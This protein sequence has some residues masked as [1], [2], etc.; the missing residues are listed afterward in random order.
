MKISLFVRIIGMVLIT[1]VLVGGV[2]YWTSFY[3]LSRAV[4]NYSQS[5]VKEMAG[6][7]R[8]YVDSLKDKAVTTTGLLAERQELVAALEK[9]NKEAVQNLANSYVKARQV[10]VLTVTDKDGNVVA[11]GH[12]DKAGDN[13]ST[14][15]AVKSTLAGQPFTGIEEGTIAKLSLRAGNPIKSGNV[16]IGSVTA[17][18]D[19]SSESFVDEVKKIYGVECTIFQGDTRAATTIM[20]DGKRAIGTR[21]DNPQVIETVLKKGEMFLNVNKI[22]GKNYDTAYWPLK[23]VEG[24]IVGMFFIGKDREL[25]EKA[26]YGTIIPAF[27]AALIIGLIM[28]AVNYYS[29][30]RIVGVLNH[31]ISGLTTSHEQVSA[32]SAHVA[33]ASQELAEGT[34][35]QAASL[36]ET[37][38]SLGEMSS[39]TIQNAD[40]AE[41]A[42]TMTEDAR[43]VVEKVSG[44]M[45]EMSSAIEEITKMSEDT[46]KIVKNIDEIAFQ[47]NLLALN[48]A[49]EAA[50]AGE[51]GAGFAVVA[52]EVRNLAMRAAEAAKTTSNLIENTIKAVGKGN[53][54][55]I[56]TQN[57][58]KE[59]AEIS[60]KI[61]QLVDEI[62]AS[63]K[64]QA[65]GIAQVSSAVSEMDKVT[66][67]AAANAE[68]SASS[69]EEMKTQAK[70][71]KVFVEDLVAIVLGSNDKQGRSSVERKGKEIP[72]LR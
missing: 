57:A 69:S 38:A 55:T 4:Y 52:D 15:V 39:M 46:S 44:H 30:Q 43:H 48:A 42:R 33:L 28:A 27:I 29:V 6:L 31:V 56:A 32:A 71:M 37:S 68:A 22:L 9:G 47:T 7:A 64:E 53:D 62:A 41:H 58:F 5:E 24:K 12:S 13:V 10:S 34:S 59:N 45:D 26:L 8:G 14:Q 61:G 16:V 40:S 50:R 51:A 70:E 21:M 66:Q 36:E 11:R 20:K 3:L 49:V 18:F 35:E 2:V 23:D 67:Q 72:L 19:L 65:K 1:A 54:L 17:G 60:L 63:S 25:M